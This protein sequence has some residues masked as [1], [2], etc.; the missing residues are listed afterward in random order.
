M[1]TFSE[2]QVLKLAPDESSAKSGMEL[3]SGRKWV[4][5]GVSELGLWGEC[6]GSGKSPYRTA[7]DFAGPAFKCS[8]PSRKFPCKHGLGL[9]LFYAKDPDTFKQ[10]DFP[11]WAAS[12]I[13][14]RAI[15]AGKKAERD[16]AAKPPDPVAKAKR[17][18]DRVAK[19][20]SG[21]AD[22]NRFLED[23]IR[24]GLSS[25]A[26]QGRGMW[27]QQAARL[28]DAQAPGLARMLRQ[29][30][31]IPNSHENWPEHLLARMSLVHLATQGYARLEDLS[32]DA[33]DDI[34]NIVGF[35]VS[36]EELLKQ[37]GTKDLWQVLGQRVEVDEKL[38][39]QRTWLR[40]MESK[41]WALILQFAYGNAPLDVSFEQGKI[42]EAELVFFPG[43]LK[44]RALAKNV[45][46]DKVKIRKLN[47]YADAEEFLLDYAKAMALNPWTETFPCALSNVLPV[48]LGNR[49]IVLVDT[50][51]NIIPLRT[52]MFDESG[53]GYWNLLAISGGK[54][55]DL[56][57]EWSGRSLLPLFA[58]PAAEPKEIVAMATSKSDADVAGGSEIGVGQN[59]PSEG[60]AHAN[61]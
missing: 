3:S 11:E 26:S 30:S 56:F 6:Q 7:I 34:R 36:Q 4:G 47:A 17:Q 54:Q 9:L 44:M 8:C 60:G 61:I 28:T 57:G 43:S 38:K 20:D 37:A 14:E 50:N 29:C 45:S 10:N 22:L 24:Q 16:S 33:Q 13:E 23:R 55:L 52:N 1:T 5:F 21:I 32:P 39:T 18:A 59:N 19:V 51:R 2:E 58:V 35:T 49:E 46:N 15:K 42:V 27:E 41:Q 25:V 12:W 31:D 48:P 40:G 53:L